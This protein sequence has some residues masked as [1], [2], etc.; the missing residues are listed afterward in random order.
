MH[1]QSVNESTWSSGFEQFKICLTDLSQE[2]NV[3]IIIIIII[4]ADG[5]TLF[6]QVLL[7]THAVNCG[8]SQENFIIVPLS[9][10]QIFL[11]RAV[12]KEKRSFTVGSSLVGW[13]VLRKIRPEGYV[14]TWTRSAS[15]RLFV[16]SCWSISVCTLQVS[17]QA[18][19]L[20]ELLAIIIFLTK[21]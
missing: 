5:V 15:E 13:L 6:F 2:I 20:L 8:I 12:T 3:C 9:S 17:S 21:S 14:W 10:H 18:K 11:W 1:S 4:K 19:S 7:S 16:P